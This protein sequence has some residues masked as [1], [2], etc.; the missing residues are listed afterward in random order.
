MD[1]FVEYIAKFLQKAS[2]QSIYSMLFPYK[3]QGK[4]RKHSNIC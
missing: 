4:I 1:K 2:S 3:Y